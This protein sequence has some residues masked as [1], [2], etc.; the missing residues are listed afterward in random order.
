MKKGISAICAALAPALVSAGPPT[1][2][3]QLIVTFDT[4][5]KALENAAPQAIEA[6]SAALGQRI[7]HIRLMGAGNGQ[8]L[9]LP[10]A[11]SLDEVTKL[12]GRVSTFTGGHAEPDVRMVP[13][14]SPDDPRYTEQWHY[15]G[16]WGINAPPAWDSSTGSGVVVAVL[17]TGYLPHAD[18]ASNVL[19]GYDMIGDPFVANDGNGRDPNAS[20]PGDH[21]AAGACGQG[22]PRQDQASS[23]HGTHVAGTIAAVTNN[24]AGVAGVAY[25]AKI[26][27]VRVLGR[28]G[29]YSSDISDGIRWAA[30]LS[31]TGVPGNDH[32]AQVINLSLG[33][34]YTCTDLSAYQVAI[35]AATSA[36]A[37]VVVSAGN[38][39]S[40]AAEYSPAGCDGV[41]TVAATGGTGTRSYYSNYG[42]TVEIAAPGGDAYVDTG[43]LSTLNSG[44]D[45][46]SADA[47]AN[48]QG[49][50]MAAPHVSGVAALMY[51]ADSS[52]TANRVI[53]I[54]QNTA[55]PFA[56]GSD[57]ASRGC[58]AGIVDAAAAVAE[59]GGSQPPPEPLPTIPATPS[60]LGVLNN[61]DGTANVTWDSPTD[62][63][64]S[65]ELNREKAHK[66]R[67]NSWVE[68]AI[69]A[70]PS[71]A[72]P[73]S[74]S[75]GAGSF[76][77][78]IRG[79]NP[80]GY[81]AWS[82]WLEVTVTE[83]SGS[84]GGDDPEKPCR[85][86]KCR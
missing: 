75:P 11:L 1:H 48:Y 86:K 34:A 4:P 77:Y 50:S 27:P 21:V 85:G 64:E 29:G 73:Y 36:G 30:G 59:V 83:E 56:S 13:M 31:V 61:G 17:D 14:L 60:G 18:L 32:P 81:S 38:S 6:L 43:V 33:G 16:T 39:N 45:A 54:M 7:N 65:V 53:D 12:A 55:K 69:I 28:C 57:C 72:G 63:T 66:K 44:Y 82:E 26:L 10:R 9:K 2:T 68:S 37:T 22:Y 19:S 5:S 51:S 25:D 49:T 71:A 8:V 42:S 3:D 46:P 76:R 67:A 78:R 79:L 40:N 74:D 35:N 23:W 70:V 84:S 15:H 24:N 47:Y 41:I 58:G 20:D 52:L 62:S 80:A